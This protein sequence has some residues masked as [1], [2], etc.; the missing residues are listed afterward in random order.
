VLALIAM[1]PPHLPRAADLPALTAFVRG[2]LHED[3]LAE[4]GSALDAATAFAGD[5]S[6]DERRQ[7]IDELERVARALDGRSTTDVTRFFAHDLRSAWTPATID[8]VRSLIARLR[9]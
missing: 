1:R 9:E 3:V 2:Y 5:A 8:D 4:H 7:L 6:R